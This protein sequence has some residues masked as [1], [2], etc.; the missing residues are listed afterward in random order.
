MADFLYDV[1]INLRNKINSKEIEKINN[2]REYFF[3]IGQEVYYLLS[4][5]KSSKKTQSLVNPF[6]NAKNNNIIKE[7]LINLYKKYNYVIDYNSK[8]SDKLY[9]MILGYETEGKVNQ[10]MIIAG[11]LSNSLI[12]E[13]KDEEKIDE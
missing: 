7:K 4:L 2:D 13:K 1:Q 6:I 5:N 12:Y 8:R 3:A 9:S 11:F 10:D